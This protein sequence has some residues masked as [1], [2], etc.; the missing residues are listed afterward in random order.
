MSKPLQSDG[1]NA[2]EVS[3]LG[4]DAHGKAASAKLSLAQIICRLVM[5]LVLVVVSGA[6]CALVLAPGQVTSVY[7]SLTPNPASAPTPT[8]T[9]T[10][11]P[12]T[13]ARPCQVATDRSRHAIGKHTH[14]NSHG[15]KP[16]IRG[17]FA[18]S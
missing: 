15:A 12:T 14:V 10:P 1:G 8:R 17:D 18:G 2:L 4:A 13:E 9:P 6:I 11:A 5:L 7:S 16:N 3:L